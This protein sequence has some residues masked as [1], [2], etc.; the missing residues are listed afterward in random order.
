LGS[1]KR[2]IWILKRGLHIL[3]RAMYFL[4][5]FSSILK[6]ALWILKR[7]LCIVKRARGIDPGIFGILKT[8]CFWGLPQGG[9]DASDALFL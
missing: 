2:V 1:L 7:G 9:E 3:K 6:R 4:G 8:Q 5:K